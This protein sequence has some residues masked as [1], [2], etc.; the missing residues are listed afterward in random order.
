MLKRQGFYTLGKLILY[1]FS[2]CNSVVVL[3]DESTLENS[4]KSIQ[5]FPHS[6]EVL[7]M[8]TAS[9]R[10]SYFSRLACGDTLYF[11]VQPDRIGLTEYNAPDIE[12]P[13]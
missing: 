13:Q 11:M 8:S 1:G 2:F 5:L 3:T 10:S 4:L 9:D 6:I 7:A 12:D